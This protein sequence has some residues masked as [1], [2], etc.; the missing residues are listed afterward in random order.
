M[1]RRGRRTNSCIRF[2]SGVNRLQLNAD[3]SSGALELLLRLPVPEKAEPSR[4]LPMSTVAV[5]ASST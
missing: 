4:Y 2:V 1:M 5:I 3:Y